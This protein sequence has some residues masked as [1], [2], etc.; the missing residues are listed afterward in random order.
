[1]DKL[2]IRQS[3]DLIIFGLSST[4]LRLLRPCFS[5][6]FDGERSDLL[7]LL[8]D[9]IFH[10]LLFDQWFRLAVLVW[11]YSSSDGIGKGGD[12]GTKA[13]CSTL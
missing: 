2:D 8:D 9:N 3:W 11:L 4:G 13:S 7:S 5:D 6:F 1:M 12:G 10:L